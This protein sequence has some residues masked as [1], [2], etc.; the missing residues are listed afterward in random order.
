[1]FPFTL[2]T[3]QRFAEAAARLGIAPGTHVVAYAQD[4]P[5]WATR[6]WWQLRFI[7]FDAV[8][9]LDGGLPA[10]RAAGLPTDAAPARYDPAVFAAVP[11]PELLATRADVDRVVADGGA[12]LVNALT[13]RV[14]QGER[15]SSYSRPGRISGS[16]NTPSAALIDP[17]TNRFRAPAELEQELGAAGAL[18]SE[19]LIAYCGGGI[20]ASIDLFALA[21]L[22][23]EQVRLYDGSLTE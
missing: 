7:G 17:D 18:G 4:T 9:V 3:A 16:V 6:L 12:F 22:G 10:W 13:P 1:M 14:F 20:S 2:P 19:P 11:R 15:P 5:M 21:L 23:R 8:S